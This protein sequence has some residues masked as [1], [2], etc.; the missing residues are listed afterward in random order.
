MWASRVFASEGH[1]GRKARRYIPIRLRV[2]RDKGGQAG[3]VGAALKRGAT[4]GSDKGR[5]MV[6]RGV[7]R[8]GAAVTARGRKSAGGSAGWRGQ[9]AVGAKARPEL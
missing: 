7:A 1:A 4:G 9:I 2:A 8:G 3:E 6:Y 5:T